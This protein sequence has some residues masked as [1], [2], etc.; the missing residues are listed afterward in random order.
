MNGT[1]SLDALA[2]FV[3]VAESVSFRGAA[4]RL[5]VPRSTVSR[6]VAGLERELGARLLKRTT[7]SVSLTDAGKRY[8]EECQPAL[9]QLHEA[10]RSVRKTVVEA[11][12]RLRITAAPAFGERY[13]GP[14]AERY[15]SANPQVELE[16]F[17]TDRHVDLVQEGFDLAFRAGGVGDESLVARELGRGTLRCVAS[18]EYLKRRGRPRRPAD[19]ATHECVVYPP[20]A[21]GGRWTFRAAERTVNVAV[22]GRL[23]VSSLPMAFDAAVRG[24]GVSRIPSA[25]AD[26]ALGRNAVVELLAGF[27]P[28]PSP[29]FVV[30]RQGSQ[31]IPRLSAFLDLVKEHVELVLPP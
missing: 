1:V 12:G 18:P 24:L 5:G 8:L 28:T 17:L 19:L 4:D 6:K 10:A 27:V 2:V 29:F 16:I 20:L 26:E 15:L 21:R 11:S 14:I 30:Y 31:A 7:R 25:L 22:R 9:S 13:L 23:I 3:Q